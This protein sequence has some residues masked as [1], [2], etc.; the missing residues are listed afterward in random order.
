MSAASSTLPTEALLA[1]LND[2]AAGSEAAMALGVQANKLRDTDPEAAEAIVDEL[3]KRYTNATAYGKKLT[4]LDALGNSGHPKAFPFLE[5][6]IHSQDLRF[7]RIGTYG[8]RFVPGA[9]ADKVLELQL[10]S[11]NKTMQL[12]AVRAIGFRSAD[13]WRDR[14]AALRAGMAPDVQGSIDRVLRMWT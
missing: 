2:S 9:D 14:L 7:E 3:V 11:A 12:A 8:M 6:A 5:E 10:A 1:A 13:T 4:Y